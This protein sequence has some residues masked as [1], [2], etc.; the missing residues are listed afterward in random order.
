MKQTLNLSDELGRLAASLDIPDD[1]HESA[2][3]EYER[4]AE[5]LGQQGSPLH[6]YELSIYPA[7]EVPFTASNVFTVTVRD[8]EVVTV[9]LGGERARGARVRGGSMRMAILLCMS[10]PQ[11]SLSFVL[12]RSPKDG[13]P[14]PVL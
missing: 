4:V 8:G 5:W 14:T 1:L 10:L 11:Q 13:S 2:I 7:E 9:D 12:L 6:H 3:V